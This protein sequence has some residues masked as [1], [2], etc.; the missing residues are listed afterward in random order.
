M[1]RDKNYECENG[2]GHCIFIRPLIVGA[3]L[4]GSTTL[5]PGSLYW[6]C[7][8]VW[9]VGGKFLRRG[10]YLAPIPGPPGSGLGGGSLRSAFNSDD[11]AP[12]VLS[13][14]RLG[15]RPCPPGEG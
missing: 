3:I 12:G 15:I 5:G 9:S 2:H 14:R 7:R 10:D 6:A 4:Q 13:P 11:F 1:A 8:V